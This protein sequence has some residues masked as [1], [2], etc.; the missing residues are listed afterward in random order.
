MIFGGWLGFVRVV[1]DCDVASEAGLFGCAK[2][3]TEKA[4][5][6]VEKCFKSCPGFFIVG[7]GIP[8]FAIF[9]V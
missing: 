6:A 5:G 4:L 2:S 1:V 7:F 9:K 8:G 3:V